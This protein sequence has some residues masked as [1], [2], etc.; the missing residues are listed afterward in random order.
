M[1]R[2]VLSERV[3][4]YMEIL[5]AVVYLYLVVQNL[6]WFVQPLNERDDYLPLQIWFEGK[7]DAWKGK[8]KILCPWFQ[9]WIAAGKK[10]S[11]TANPVDAARRTVR[12]KNS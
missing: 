3:V 12:V 7:L 6:I 8:L 5:L 9:E 10:R 1:L 4:A 11:K 2:Y